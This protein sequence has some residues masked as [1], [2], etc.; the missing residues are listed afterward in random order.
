M[1]K[2]MLWVILLSCSVS[3]EAQVYENNL[4]G[5]KPQQLS[6]ESEQQMVEYIKTNKPSTFRY[7]ERLDYTAKKKV[8]QQHQENATQ[9]ITDIIIRVYRQHSRN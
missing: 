7:F 6:F 5:K 9:D 4:F 3:I 8:F 1:K 2:V